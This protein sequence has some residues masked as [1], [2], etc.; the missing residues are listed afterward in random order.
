MPKKPAPIE[1]KTLRGVNLAGWLVLESWVTPEIFA[2]TGALD[3]AG[4]IRAVGMTEYSEIAF[5][6]RESFIT[7]KDFERIAAR[8]F[9]AVRIPVPWYVFG[10]QGPLPGKFKGC[11]SELDHAF[12][13]AEAHGIRILLDLAEVPAA[14]GSDGI[15]ASPTI[16]YPVCREAALD[17][18]CALARRY[19][20][21]EGFLGVEVLDEPVPQIRHGI[22]V[23]D[24]VP[25]HYLRNFYRDAYKGI[26]EVAGDDCVVV[27]SD[28][29]L[30]GA[31]KGFMAS[32]EYK[33]VWLD[34]HLYHYA[35]SIDASGPSGARRL[36]AAS[37]KTLDLAGK[38]G[39]PVIVGEWSGA[40]PVSD[41]QMTPE[42]RMA[43]ERVY[44]SAQLRAFEH[45]RAWFFQTWKTSALLSNWDARV[46]L[47]SF[48]AG[49][50]D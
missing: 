19:K 42:G 50:L 15:G 9:E 28:A 26:R 4:L 29:G 25:L 20:D 14:G 48:E 23:S 5:R 37:A 7:E 6:H 21:R 40:L 22:F 35:D 33:N 18:L 8:G 31:W 13:W 44:A 43:I 17:V 49:M 47:A 41:A 38:S 27:I 16:T 45:A 11:A 2:A 30:P 34:C 36:V 12:D 39:L 10:E 1:P 46:A 3:E 24:G 32:K